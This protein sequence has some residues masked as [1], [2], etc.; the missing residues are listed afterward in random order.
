MSPQAFTDRCPQRSATCA[1]DE[2]QQRR[3]HPHHRAA[4]YRGLPG[5]VAEAGTPRRDLSRQF[6]RLVLGARRG[7][8]RRERTGRRQGARRGAEVEWVEEPSY[9]FRLSAWQERL[10]AF[11]E[12]N[13]DFIAP[14]SR[15]NEV[16]SFVKGGLAGSLG[17]AHQLQLGRAGAGR[18]QACHVCLARRAHQLH[19]R[20]RL[21]RHRQLRVCNLLAG[22]PAHGRQGHPALPRGL[23][24]GLP[25]GGRAAPPQRVFAHGW[26]TNEGQKISKSL[27]NVIE[28]AAGRQPTASTRCAISCCA[29]CR[30]ATTA[31]SRIAPWSAA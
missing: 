4:P 1:A 20:G 31:T 23:L 10:L 30:S 5:A 2:L 26:W 11:Y 18:S 17:L 21:S 12:A 6:C 9:F 19:H 3:F 14:D 22:R 15:R 13:P 16:I 24:A 7:L 28:P 25:D 27:G 29:R 8:L